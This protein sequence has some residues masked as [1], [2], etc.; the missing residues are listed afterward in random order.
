MREW[1]DGYIY[2]CHDF[3]PDHNANPGDYAALREPGMP[4]AIKEANDSVFAF[5]AV[6]KATTVKGTVVT[7]EGDVEVVALTKAHGRCVYVFAQGD[8][9]SSH[10]D[11]LAVNAE[12]SVGGQTGTKMVSE[13]TDGI[14]I[15]H[16]DPY[17]LHIYRIGG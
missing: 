5:G 13:L 1:A 4:E 3:S 12:I 6:L 10:I 9:D 16:F 7:T 15:D 17:E 14:I 11:G 8:G 2:F